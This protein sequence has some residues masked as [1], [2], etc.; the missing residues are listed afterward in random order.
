MKRIE[1]EKWFEIISSAK[2]YLFAASRVYLDKVSDIV[3]AVPESYPNPIL[4]SLMPLQVSFTI[5]WPLVLFGSF[6]TLTFRY[7]LFVLC[8]DIAKHKE[9]T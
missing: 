7:L 9:S 1:C 8:I 4:M 2:Q 5:H 3:H 6:T